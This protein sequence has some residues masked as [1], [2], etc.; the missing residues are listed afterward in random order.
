MLLRSEER[1]KKPIGWA[2]ANERREFL[3]YTFTKVNIMT[4][5]ND[6]KSW[7]DNLP[8]PKTWLVYIAIK[9]LVLALVVYLVLRY[10][11]LV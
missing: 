9:L 6:R 10:N 5:P 7:H 11:A 2:K 1:A 4:T 8:F 3:P